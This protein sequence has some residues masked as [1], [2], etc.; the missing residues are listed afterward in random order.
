MD[1]Q[2]QCDRDLASAVYHGNVDALKELI[3]KGGNPNA[4][5]YNNEPLLLH[6]AG[7]NKVEVVRYLLNDLHVPIE[8]RDKHGHTALL[9]AASHGALEVLQFLISAGANILATNAL[10]E[11]AL[12]LSA[13]TESVET[14]KFLQQSGIPMDAVDIRGRTFLHHAAE[15]SYPKMVECIL[16]GGW[17]PVDCL[18]K[19]GQTPLM[20]TADFPRNERDPVIHSSWFTCEDYVNQVI[21]LLLSAG[22]DLSRKD[23]LGRT[24]LH[25]TL[26]NRENFD[27][28]WKKCKDF[29][30]SVDKKGQT[31]IHRALSA[32]RFHW[33]MH[34]IM[35]LLL[36]AGADAKSHDSEGRTALYIALE[37]QCSYE[38]QALIKSGAET[39]CLEKD[40]LTKI[41]HIAVR[42]DDY[43]QTNRMIAEGADVNG[44][45]S[46][47]RDSPST[48]K[49]HTIRCL[50]C[51]EAGGPVYY[52]LS[53][54]SPLFEALRSPKIFKLLIDSG[55]NVNFKDDHGCTA[56]HRAVADMRCE[57]LEMLLDAGADPNIVDDCGVSS[58]HTLSDR[59][60]DVRDITKFAERLLQAGASVNVADHNGRTPLHYATKRGDSKHVKILLSAGANVHAVDV[61]GATPL[62]ITDKRHF[63]QI[64][65]LLVDAG[66]NVNLKDA[67]GCSPLQKAVDN[68]NFEAL[69]VLLDA[70]ADP[71]IV[72]E[73]GVSL[74]NIVSSRPV[75]TKDVPKF[76]ERLLQ[77][78]ANV[79][80]KDH[81]GITTLHCAAKT[82][83]CKL[84]EILLSAGADVN[85]MDVNG[86]TPL[87]MTSKHCFMQAA[88]LLLD[89]GANLIASD[90][91][92]QQIIHKASQFGDTTA[93][94]YLVEKW[95]STWGCDSHGNTVL[96]FAARSR[97]NRL[98]S[99]EHILK[100]NLVS[101]DERNVEG[102]TALAMLV[103][104]GSK[105]HSTHGE[106]EILLTEGASPT[107]MDNNGKMPLH[108]A[109]SVGDVKVMEVLTAAGADV[110][111]KDVTGRTPLHLAAEAH[112]VEGLELLLKKAA[113]IDEQDSDGQTPLMLA[114]G[115]STA[116]N[117]LLRK[118]VS[119]SVKNHSGKTVLE[120]AMDH[121]SHGVVEALVAAGADVTLKDVT[122]RTPLHWA[123]KAHSVEGLELL[124]KKAASIDEQDSDG[125]TPLMLAVGSSNAVNLLLRKG[126]SINVK[127]HSGKTALEEAMD[128]GSHG[129]VK[130]LWTA[131][132]NLK[133]IPQ[134]YCI[135]AVHVAVKAGDEEILDHL[136]SLGISL[137][138]CWWDPE[139]ETTLLH[140]AAQSSVEMLKKLIDNGHT[141]STHD[142]KGFS[143]LHIA[144]QSL[145][146][147]G[148]KYL[149]E[150]ANVPV[151]ERN[152]DGRT[153]LMLAV[154]DSW[155]YPDVF[156]M[157]EILVNAG[158][159]INAKDKYGKT[160]YQ[161]AYYAWADMTH[162]VLDYMQFRL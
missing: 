64:I 102:Q 62:L 53:G 65:K 95:P 147:M 89:A 107:T 74:L 129:A 77:A 47:N 100:R 37:K 110:T 4:K 131:V 162:D 134:E 15:F 132:S 17:L 137:S 25:R 90:K 113:S 13:R 86:A 149:L 22:A 143:P 46:F 146:F 69:E 101:V 73:C 50:G 70:G 161:L 9:T 115:S 117:L 128:H 135:K 43:E 123:A 30:H 71:N 144:V 104:R 18:D 29:T 148:T 58:L 84:I 118:G 6:A 52:E 85:S 27:F 12:H 124:L 120:E 81:N 2:A 94:D 76:A 160:A 19:N 26:G 103:E 138:D 10:E 5:G 31:P 72:D 40:S 54:E 105:S 16:Q 106:V 32:F 67:H 48:E 125:Q 83:N 82:G 156:D 21:K 1:W 158:A 28:L 93:I 152:A 112:N 23:V 88:Q 150:D 49:G 142:H 151:N 87:H 55:A 114:V 155:Y 126:A 61:N 92:G 60:A 116:V 45:Q 98:I 38:V 20:L 33:D 111:S 141:E 36:E 80:L 11:T 136:I 121:G 8:I 59:R 154:S 127:N 51:Y 153:A 78:G 68:R 157:L 24:T 99:I 159:D 57:V 122:G 108:T 133:D 63:T 39:S 66:A 56:L 91:D 35:R 3:S 44:R 41:L 97:R 14:F 96:H 42:N 140:C 79:N 75:N 145:N 130:L 7:C 119:I 34:H 109:A 139:H